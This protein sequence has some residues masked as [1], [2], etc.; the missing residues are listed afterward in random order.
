MRKIGF[1]VVTQTTEEYPAV[2]KSS[3]EKGMIYPSP[4]IYIFKMDPLDSEEDIKIVK[5]RPMSERC[6][7][8]RD[9][10]LN[11]AGVGIVI[12]NP[13]K[14]EFSEKLKQ[15]V[16]IAIKSIVDDLGIIQYQIVTDEVSEDAFVD[17]LDL[18]ALVDITPS[19]FTKRF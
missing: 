17:V 15:K 11:R 10:Q 9:S 12:H 19:I 18:P 16:A 1:F 2:V 14:S 8:V 5:M 6:G 7:T 3:F 4:H 13:T